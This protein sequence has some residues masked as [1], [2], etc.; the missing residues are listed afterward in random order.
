MFSAHINP[1]TLEEQS[2]K[3]H[4]ESVAALSKEYGAKISLDA[5]AEVIGI[6][7]DMGKG[8]NIF[9]S[10]IHYCSAHP[11]DKSLRGSINHS[12]AGAK[13]IY[14][15]FYNTN[16]PY[17][18]LTA[19]LISLAIC[20]HHGGL[21][22][23][24]D[25][26]GIDIFTD[27][28][29]T[30]KE[31]FYDEALSNFTAEYL[32]M[33]HINE[34]FYKA[35][36]EIKAIVNKINTIEKSAT[37][38]KFAAGTL[39]KYLFS[40]VIDADRYDTYTFM[41]GCDQPQSSNKSALWNELADVLDTKLKSYPKLSKIDLLRAEISITCKEFGKNKPGIY[42]L[43]V[44]TGGGK[45]LSSLRYA[46]EHAKQFNKD[47][48]L[49]IIPFT[50]I[51]DQNARDIKEILGREDVILE[52]HS[53]LVIETENDNERDNYKLLTERWDSPIILTTMVQFL[54]TLFSGG[55]QNVRRMHNLANSI[56]I[57]DEIQAIP[58]KCIN[59]FNSAINFLSTI[60]KATIILCTATQPLLSITE[61]PLKLAENPNIISNMDAR[62]EEF[63]RVNLVDKRI[64][65]GYSPASLK[66]LVLDMMDRVDSV[67]VIA[68]T[69]NSAKEVFNELKRANA[70]L[71]EAKQYSIFHLSTSMCP[72][73]RMKILDEMKENLGKVTVICVST[74][75]IEAGVNISFG[76]VVR[77]LAGLDSI[78]QAAGRCNR[79]GET[80]C[81]DVYIVNVEGEDVSKLVD[82]KEG[83]ECTRRVLDEFKEN[84]NMF[85]NDLLSP[86]VMERYYQYY[87]H[88]R[89]K[90]MN[91][92]LSKPDQ[93]KS[94]Y[95]LLAGNQ[96]AGKAFEGRNGYR[97][98]LMLKQAFKTAGN[99]FQVIAQNTTGVI[100]P[101]GE[102]KTLI[103]HIN[104]Q[105]NLRELKKYLKRAQQFSV[106]LFE[107][108][109]RRLEEMGGIV[110][111][112]AGTILALREGFYKEDIGVT[113]ES[114]PME[115]Y[116]H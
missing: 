56:I 46:L 13:F 47:R 64:I 19:Q 30:N 85:D 76:C 98:E 36:D 34:L 100:V 104:G 43:S 49:Y 93:D 14:D 27:K 75:L 39:E 112:K 81:S 59:M 94:M 44:P 110:S 7:H 87:F 22:D 29:N 45:T 99:H 55:T 33:E 18:K 3:E 8:T 91:Y 35:K 11:F 67:L 102:G 37:F 108:D 63:K 38:G 58:I 96:E 69:K 82:I 107:T 4:L 40:C 17:Q 109:K 68:N 41:E 79:H 2:V 105:C 62:F 88:N 1:T 83:Q 21:I 95:D 84:P 92:T 53:N 28:M 74:Q 51:I 114:V 60:C 54:N 61:R 25:L 78:A 6:L 9:N 31:I 48:I 113:F 23:C 24:L 106:N 86:K 42:Q 70:D 90:E 72:A 97:S 50:T 10:Y 15:N 20:S 65:G 26:K 73:H 71:P 5:T 52:H 116:N 77:S 57:F 89:K 111:L 101:Y 103:T 115:F 32:E 80:S 12:T 66:D 16:D